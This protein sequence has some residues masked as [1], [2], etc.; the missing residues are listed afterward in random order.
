M[1]GE[2]KN[3]YTL[4]YQWLSLAQGT[5]TLAWIN[6]TAATADTITVDTPLFGTLGS[7]T[8]QD[9]FSF[10]VTAAGLAVAVVV[11]SAAGTRRESRPSFSGRSRNRSTKLV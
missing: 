5:D 1:V 7:A 2:N 11:A 10:Q 4:S 9:F 8:D 6:G 3:H